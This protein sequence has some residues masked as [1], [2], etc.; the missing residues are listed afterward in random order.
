MNI[1]F[2][3]NVDKKDAKDDKIAAIPQ[4]ILIQCCFNFTTY[5]EISSIRVRLHNGKD[6]PKYKKKKMKIHI[7]ND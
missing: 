5:S 1:R 4:C 3:N 7:N 2:H 6:Y